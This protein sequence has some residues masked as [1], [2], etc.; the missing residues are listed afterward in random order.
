MA[1]PLIRQERQEGNTRG[2]PKSEPV[3]EFNP[4]ED[5]PGVFNHL[6]VIENMVET[7]HIPLARY[8]YPMG[9]LNMKQAHVLHG[10]FKITPEQISLGKSR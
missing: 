6:V 2:Y 7:Q 8:V 5:V 9:H 3:H 10:I 4:C 1:G